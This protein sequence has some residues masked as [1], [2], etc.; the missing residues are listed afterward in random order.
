MQLEMQQKNTCCYGILRM[1]M[2]LRGHLEAQLSVDVDKSPEEKM[3]GS[4]TKQPMPDLSPLFRRN[5]SLKLSTV[6]SVACPLNT[7]D[8][9]VKV[10]QFP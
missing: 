5:P 4:L 10:A 3:G 9:A 2:P 8:L 7:A 6:C 1:P